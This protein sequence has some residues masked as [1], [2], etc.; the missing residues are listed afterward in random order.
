M[1]ITK[2]RIILLKYLKVIYT[3][4]ALSKAFSI[5]IAGILVLIFYFNSDKVYS[6][7][8]LT[9]VKASINNR[10]LI[11]HT[12]NRHGNTYE[13]IINLNG[14]NDNFVI[15]NS[16]IDFFDRTNFE[17]FVKIGD[18]VF[19]SISKNKKAEL[20]TFSNIKLYG[21]SGYRS[22]YLD[23]RKAIEMDNSKMGIYLGIALILIG[24]IMF[25]YHKDKMVIVN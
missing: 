16:L 24:F 15:N 1:K 3:S 20:N 6:E 25:Y 18:P 22:V 5:V 12:G 9:E 2:N 19:V 4:N 7:Y 17:I 10:R 23:Y 8:G 11:K 14:Y 21:I 13:Y